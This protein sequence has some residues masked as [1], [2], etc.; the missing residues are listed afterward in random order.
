M[1]GLTSQARVGVRPRGAV[2][3]VVTAGSV[4]VLAGVVTTA[5]RR[6]LA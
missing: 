5:L 3:G 2:P 1:C 4:A 6:A